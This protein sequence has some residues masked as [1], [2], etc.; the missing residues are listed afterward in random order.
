VV[1]LGQ[2]AMAFEVLDTPVAVGWEGQS[3]VKFACTANV[4][5]MT[6]VPVRR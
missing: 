2:F 4:A 1:V 3:W 6:Y 5:D